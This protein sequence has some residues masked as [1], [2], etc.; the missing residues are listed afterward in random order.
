M[1]YD[2]R[3][4]IGIEFG[5]PRRYVAHRDMSRA[6]KRSD[7]DFGG[8]TNVEDKDALAA[9]DAR[10]ERYGFYISDLGQSRIGM[11]TR[12]RV[13]L[14]IDFVGKQFDFREHR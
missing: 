2:N 1:A 4:A 5:Q 7:R 11:L 8:F 13:A 3:L 9:I 10:L 12:A 6:G 14:R